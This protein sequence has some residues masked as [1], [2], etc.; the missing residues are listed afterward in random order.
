L[1]GKEYHIF[2][3]P[4]S[5]E[6]FEKKK[7]E[8]LNGS[9]SSFLKAME[10]F[11]RIKLETIHRFTHSIN[12]EN[13]TADHSA[14]LKNCSDCFEA[15][16]SE[17]CIHALSTEDSR[18]IHNC[19]SAGWPGC[20]RVFTSAVTRGS[21]EIAYCTYTFFSS[22]LRYCD[23]SNEVHNSFGC[24]GLQH[25]RN[26]ILNK[27]YSKDEYDE[28]LPRIIEHMKSTGE[29]GHFFS[30]AISPYAYN[31]SAAQ[32]YLPLS[33]SEAKTLGYRWLAKDKKDYI[34]PSVL[35]IPDS[36]H[37]LEAGFTKEILACEG[38][39]KNY[40]VHPR[41]LDFYKRQG[42]GI[43]RFCHICRHR[44]RFKTRN[45]LK[46]FKR[47][48]KNCQKEIKSS[49]SPERTEAVYCKK[50]YLEEID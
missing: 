44:R 2:N 13:S 16:T 18:D 1:V 34:K 47:T 27:Q 31:E 42:I 23:S 38:C 33:E 32:D 19:F 6:E 20:D 49:Y 43:P 11:E 9:Y 7:K 46:L 25:K 45:P 35:E 10:E 24:I 21:T 8:I 41:E 36:V 5:R 40:R 3:K 39:S 4:V 26:C 14:D 15:F 29:W 48:C 22:N 12:L 30:S 37:D 50:C 28:L 17:D